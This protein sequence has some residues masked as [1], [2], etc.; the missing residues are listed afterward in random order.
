VYV[1]QSENVSISTAYP[2]PLHHRYMGVKGIVKR[3]MERARFSAMLAL[4]MKRA[5]SVECQRVAR[6]VGNVDNDA[7]Q[8][9]FQTAEEFNKLLK[10]QDDEELET[11]SVEKLRAKGRA[12]GSSEHGLQG[13]DGINIEQLCTFFSKYD[14]NGDGMV[15]LEEF[16]IMV[17]TSRLAANLFTG[18]EDLECLTVK[19]MEALL[20]FDD[21]PTKHEG[22]GDVGENEGLGGLVSLVRN[23]RKDQV[24]TAETGQVGESPEHADRRYA[25]E[26][27]DDPRV[28]EIDA[29]VAELS[30][31]AYPTWREDVKM[32]ERIFLEAPDELPAWLERMRI[33]NLSK[34]VKLEQ[35]LQLSERLTD[36]SIIAIPPQHWNQAEQASK[37]DVETKSP[38]EGGGAEC[39]PAPR[40][41]LTEEEAAARKESAILRRLGFIFIAYRANYWWWEGVEMFRKFLMTWSSFPTSLYRFPFPCRLAPPPLLPCLCVSLLFL[42]SLQLCTVSCFTSRSGYPRHTHAFPRVPAP[43][44]RT[45]LP[46]PTPALRG[47]R[48]GVSMVR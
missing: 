31:H 7:V 15:D 4:C 28:A 16:R 40:Q 3:K 14:A 48:V 25:L 45:R 39:P 38:D 47:A 17:R 1:K 22:P 18:S 9:A 34:K 13:M 29:L 41:E 12:I 23:A 46:T 35:V 20:L 27:R 21:W 5:C 36:A 44:T 43:R 8:F 2:N 10:I 32:A 11:I 26:D 19:Q 30:E 37:S 24:E 6:L 33:K 42:G